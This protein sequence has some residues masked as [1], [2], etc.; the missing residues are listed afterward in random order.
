MEAASL[1]VLT[2]IKP[3]G[4]TR[5]KRGSAADREGQIIAI[6]PLT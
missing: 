2:W 3:I 1:T 5:S 4:R 6:P